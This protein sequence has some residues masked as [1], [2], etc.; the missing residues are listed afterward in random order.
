MLTDDMK[1][2]LMAEIATAESMHSAC[3]EA[4]QTVQK[5]TGWVS[6]ETL[7]DIADFLGMTPAELDAVAT[8]Y[9][10]IYRKPVGAHV[11]LICESVSCWIMGYDQLKKN[12]RDRL[13]IG[14]G[15]TSAD[16]KFTLLPVQ[17]LGACDGAPAMMI[18]DKLF[19]NVDAAA[20]D[21]ALK[22]YE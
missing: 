8:F 16:G 11:I 2:D 20:L 12:I 9:N 17:C 4:M 15:E 6:D 14:L 10:H 7:K 18:D 19:V 3:I 5:Y 13:G 21:E 1:R 22:G